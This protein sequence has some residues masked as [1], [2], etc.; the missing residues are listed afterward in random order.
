MSKHFA[1][2]DK[3]RVEVLIFSILILSQE[4]LISIE[5]VIL[6]IMI[7]LSNDE[8]PVLFLPNQSKW[9]NGGVQEL[10]GHSDG[11]PEFLCGDGRTFQKRLFLICPPSSTIYKLVQSNTCYKKD[12]Y[13]ND[14]PFFWITKNSGGFI[15]GDMCYLEEDS[16]RV[17]CQSISTATPALSNVDIVSPAKIVLIVEK[18]ASFQTLLDDDF[19]TKL[20]PCISITVCPT[21]LWDTLHIPIFALVDA[22]PYMIVVSLSLSLSLSLSSLSLSLFSLSLLSLS[23]LSLSQALR[24]STDQ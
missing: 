16:T 24:S 19:C 12:I 5:K 7:S 21:S 23:S 13:Y 10:V 14:T 9:V 17:D 8:A 18:D 2:V 3:F 1:E 20:S 15:S 6:E 4:L 11:A 22:D